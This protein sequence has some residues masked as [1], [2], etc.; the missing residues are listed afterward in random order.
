MLCGCGPVGSGGGVVG[1][2]GG[3]VAT[4]GSS[5]GQGPTA[6]AFSRVLCRLGGHDEGEE[7]DGNW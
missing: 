6:F 5:W 7:I 4:Q 2:A 3:A 1:A